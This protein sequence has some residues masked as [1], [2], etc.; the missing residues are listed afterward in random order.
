MRLALLVF[1]VLPCFGQRLFVYSPLTRVGPDGEIVKADRGTLQP[2][3]ILSPGVPRNAYSSLR[4]I[5]ELDKPESYILDIGQN[6]E[7]AV[8]ATLYRESFQETADGF[9]PDMLTRVNIPYR[10]TLADFRFPGQKVASF[11]LDM[12]VERNADVD[13]V[14]V[15]PQLWVD[16]LQD[17]VVYPMEVRIQQP[18]VPA[19][20]NARALPAVPPLTAPSDAI[21]ISMTR[22]LICSSPAAPAS[23]DANGE[24]NGRQLLRR[25]IAQHLLLAK[26]GPALTAAFLKAA[27]LTNLQSW[28]AK[29]QTLP[30]GPEWY[31]RFRDAIYKTAGATD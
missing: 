10:G 26:P 13:R 18:V 3:H 24:V 23:A 28:C 12:W 1:T 8:K 17:W 6:P 19:V 7:N 14:K 31:L 11:W 2:R 30:T 25:N 16:S 20:A 5:V 29:P 22:G 21:A 4:I 9:L 15:E 27:G